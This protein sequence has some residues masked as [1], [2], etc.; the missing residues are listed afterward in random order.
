MA[1]SR[2]EDEKKNL[3]PNLVVLKKAFKLAEQWVNNMSQSSV[4]EAAPVEYEERPSRLGI[5]AVVPKVVRHSSNGPV[6]R[7]L[8]SKLNN[9]A[10][11]RKRVDKEDV[12]IDEDDEEEE[13]D[14]RTRA[15]SKKKSRRMGKITTHGKKK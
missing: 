8:F 11:K 9:G 4:N 3:Q 14:S 5:G 13:L 10:S 7:L 6:E 15:F 12:D 2:K 1:S